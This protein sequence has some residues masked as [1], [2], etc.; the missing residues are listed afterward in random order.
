MLM[1]SITST[2]RRG[3]TTPTESFP[4]AFARVRKTL[5]RALPCLL[6]LIACLPALAE[7]PGREAHKA[8]MDLK[9][10]GDAEDVALLAS[11]LNDADARVREQ[12]VCH[13]GQ[14]RNPE[15]LAHVRNALADAEPAVRL[16][17]VAAAAELRAPGSE[18]IV[19]QALASDDMQTVLTA[20]A[21]IRAQAWSELADAL[22]ARLDHAQP[23]VRAEALAGLTHLGK[24]A[25]PA[26]LVRLLGDASPALRLRSAENAALAQ[27]PSLV[28]PLLAAAKSG[29][30]SLA[31]FAL[32]ALGKQLGAKLDQTPA[33]LD[34]VNQAARH[35]HPLVRRG[36]VWALDNAGLG[37]RV[38]LFLDDASPL[39]RLA[40]VR[41]AG[42]HKAA[43]CTD[44]LFELMIQAP[45]DNY[46]QHWREPPPADP[47]LAARESLRAIGTDRV[48][49]LAAQHLA[50]LANE[51][52]QT[53]KLYVL[54][55]F[56]KREGAKDMTLVKAARRAL[57]ERDAA[58]CAY[59]LGHT[60]SKRA[61]ELQ[62]DLVRSLPVD[63]VSVAFLAE[64]LG[65]IGDKQAVKP[66][67]DVVAVCANNGRLALIAQAAQ[68]PPPLPY[69]HEVA[70]AVVEALGRLG[71]PQ[72]AQ[73]VLGIASVNVSNARLNEAAMA[74]AMILPQWYGGEH[75]KAIETYL[76]T[77]LKGNG[78][79]A[80]VQYQ[81]ARAA[82]KL[83]LKSAIE[84]L[85]VLMADRQN[86]AMIH[87]TSWALSEL[88]GQKVTPPPPNPRPGDWIIRKLRR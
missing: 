70:Q 79:P 52:K 1:R 27:D 68:Q 58:A 44:R 66:L 9:W 38:R 22:I 14:T 23:R 71:D 11:L 63:C 61:Y 48:A 78:Y 42:R 16:A 39:V 57:L 18:Q 10:Y 20:I 34:A 36:A 26:V 40:A 46:L 21:A 28:E 51:L 19:R 6:V 76:L 15:A 31:G 60:A 32:A 56:G 62:L 41:A 53:E 75:D 73:H 67:M 25:P 65:R 86:D 59:L 12:A 49:E 3:G 2:N 83:K 88:T 80:P 8:D 81:A 72:A 55:T 7:L 82:V 64:A 37:Q 84:P 77:V 29:T 47:H 50:G 13:L 85:K 45:F 4:W 54:A 17:A 74:A 24:P 30:P 69:S 33:V 87:I 43:D 35:A 5:S